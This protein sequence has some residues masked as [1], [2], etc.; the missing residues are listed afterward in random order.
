MLALY[1]HKSAR[2]EEQKMEFLLVL[3]LSRIHSCHDSAGLLWDLCRVPRVTVNETF[4][5]REQISY[6][7]ACYITEMFMRY[8]G[9][10][11]LYCRVCVT[12]STKSKMKDVDSLQV[13][14][15]SGIIDAACGSILASSSLFS[16]LASLS[17]FSRSRSCPRTVF[18]FFA[19]RLTFLV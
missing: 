2:F 8:N 10:R 1:V 9:G 19:R 5:L 12:M 15:S 17:A 6:L 16:L 7:Q 13:G 14:T 4:V 18:K 3:L 11:R